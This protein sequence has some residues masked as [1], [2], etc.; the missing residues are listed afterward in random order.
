MKKIHMIAA[1]L[2]MLLPT[3]LWAG[4]GGTTTYDHPATVNVTA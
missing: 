4:G 1:L 2:T 3:L